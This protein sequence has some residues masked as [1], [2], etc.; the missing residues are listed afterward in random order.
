MEDLPSFRASGA[1]GTGRIFGMLWGVWCVSRLLPII[2]NHPRRCSKYHM[3]A[4]LGKSYSKL[5]WAPKMIQGPIVLAR[6]FGSDFACWGHVGTFNRRLS[7]GRIDPGKHPH[8]MSSPF[9]LIVYVTWCCKSCIFYLL[10]LA[11]LFLSS[12]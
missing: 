11:D 2:T 12:S 1:E 6:S 7:F 4:F 8:E 9:P 3:Y 10:A 5:E